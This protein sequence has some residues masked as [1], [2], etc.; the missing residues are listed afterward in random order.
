MLSAPYDDCPLCGED[1]AEVMHEGWRICGT[2]KTWLTMT[3]QQASNKGVYPEWAAIT[4]HYEIMNRSECDGDVDP[5]SFD[6]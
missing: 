5:E 4:D 3:P 6:T 1:P 2:C